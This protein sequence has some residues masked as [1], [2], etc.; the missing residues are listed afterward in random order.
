MVE[1]AGGFGCD[2]PIGGIGAFAPFVDFEA[3]FGDDAGGFVVL[4]GGGELVVRNELEFGLF[5]FAL[6]LAGFGD[7]LVRPVPNGGLG[8]SRGS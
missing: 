4:I 2:L 1:E 5:G 3:K 7:G 6:P 8:R